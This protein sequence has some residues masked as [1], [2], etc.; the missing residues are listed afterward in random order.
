MLAAVA[1]AVVIEADAPREELLAAMNRLQTAKTYRMKMGEELVEYQNPEPRLR[2]RDKTKVSGFD[3]TKETIVVGK[4]MAS[5]VISPELEAHIA[6]LKATKRMSELISLGSSIRSALQSIAIGP[7]GW[8]SALSVA[9]SAARA[10]RDIGKPNPL[11]HYFQWECMELPMA[12]TPQKNSE[13]DPSL[14]VT[15]VG[16]DNT[17]LTEYRSTS[18]FQGANGNPM[19]M[20]SRSW[21]DANGFPRKTE[22]SFGGDETPPV[23]M[24]YYD[25]DAADIKIELPKCDAIEK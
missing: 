15:K 21:I 25:F 19:T 1:I 5:R 18:T 4:L 24:E 6:K 20:N 8:L 2:M 23:V 14:R 3:A 12:I 13:P 7:Y 17:G 22:L 11:E 16:T 9:R 10:A